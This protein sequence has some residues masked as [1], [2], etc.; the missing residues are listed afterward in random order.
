MIVVCGATGQVGRAVV[1]E[2]LGALHDVRA[3]VQ[4]GLAIPWPERSGLAVTVADFDDAA[5]M[6]TAIRGAE[7]LFMMSPPH[8]RQV[9]WQQIQVDAAR[10]AGVSRV[11]KLSAFDTGP[12]TRLTMG[13]WHWA[14]EQTLRAS[15]LPHAILRPQY[16]MENLLHDEGRLR[17]GLLPTFIEPERAVGMVAAADVGSVAAALLVS[18]ELDGRIVV[19]TGP[20]A[21]TTADVARALSHVLAIPVEPR[22]VA[23][24]AAMAALLAS[25]RPDWHARDVL[26]MCQDASALV[27]TDV[28]SVT[29]RAPR[30]IGSVVA[31]RFDLVAR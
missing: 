11:V 14:G 10:A 12:D 2:L 1:T 29:G 27:T 9:E 21:I 6:Q 25:G 26:M 13:R 23:G 17:A 24:D 8:E 18:G 28:A 4:P 5:A 3:L 20:V 22:L 19:P 16:F 15:G 31:S 7:A 30:D